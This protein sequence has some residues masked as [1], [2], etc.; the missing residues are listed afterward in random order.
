MLFQLILP[1]D[2]YLKCSSSEWNRHY[3]N[4][5]FVKLDHAT[6]YSI[7]SWPLNILW[8]WDFYIFQSPKLDFYLHKTMKFIFHIVVRKCLLFYVYFFVFVPVSISLNSSLFFQFDFTRLL[9][10]PLLLKCILPRGMILQQEMRLCI[11]LEFMVWTTMR[12]EFT[13]VVLLNLLG[14]ASIILSTFH[15]FFWQTQFICW[16]NISQGWHICN[17]FNGRGG[18]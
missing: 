3:K 1:R 18:T 14:P 8:C 17:Y 7:L 11:E 10:T 12:G 2:W 4:V 13:E 5:N 9:L 16:V 6:K 15:F